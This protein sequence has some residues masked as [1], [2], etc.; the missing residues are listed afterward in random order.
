MSH[1]VEDYWKL[2]IT[3]KHILVRRMAIASSSVVKRKCLSFSHSLN[4]C[5]LSM[6]INHHYIPVYGRFSH[7]RVCVVSSESVYVTDVSLIGFYD[8]SQ[9]HTAGSLI[10]PSCILM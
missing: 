3:G 9:L 7:C 1:F 5:D 4:C 10:C 8:M 6:V 2:E